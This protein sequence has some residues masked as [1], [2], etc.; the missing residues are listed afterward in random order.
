MRQ[1]IFFCYFHIKEITNKV[2]FAL[3]FYVYIVVKPIPPDAIL[4][5]RFRW[6]LILSI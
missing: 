5:F 3:S 2:P 1:N 6:Q 4:I